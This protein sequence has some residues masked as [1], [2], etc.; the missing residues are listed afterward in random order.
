MNEYINLATGT[1]LI[2]RKKVASFIEK[3]FRFLGYEFRHD[4]YKKIIYGEES[5]ETSLEEKIKSYYDAYL[6]LISNHKNSFTKDLLNKFFYLLDMELPNQSLLS[7]LTTKF[8]FYLNLTPLEAAINFHLYAYQ[9]MKCFKEDKRYF[10]SLMFF[11]FALLKFNIPT[12]RFT[13]KDYIEYERVKEQYFLGNKTLIYSFFL[14]LLKDFK[15]QNKNY[16]LELKP[17]TMKEIYKQFNADKDKLIKDYDIKHLRIYGSFSKDEERIDSDIDV[18]ISFN[19]DLTRDQKLKHIDYLSK[20]YFDIF[21]RFIDFMEL[22]ERISDELVKETT[23][24]K[25]IF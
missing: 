15:F 5:V 20:F 3:T 2:V 22:G 12:I 17:L 8:F 4:L 18:L 23:D 6:F 1:E 11:N 16:Y 14:K 9:E 19:L 10:I 21:H 7:N 25:T 13:M 24:I